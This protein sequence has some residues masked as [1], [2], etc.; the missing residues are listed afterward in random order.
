MKKLQ[1]YDEKWLK[2]WHH[3]KI[4]RKMIKNDKNALMK[5]VYKDVL[6]N[7]FYM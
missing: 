3:D 7:E 1:K 4:F 6:R 2:K 5:L